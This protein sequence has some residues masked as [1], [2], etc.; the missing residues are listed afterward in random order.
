MGCTLGMYA[1]LYPAQAAAAV[2]DLASVH[3]ALRVAKVQ[4]RFIARDMVAASRA[5]VA[6]PSDDAA[7]R[8]LMQAQQA[9]LAIPSWLCVLLDLNHST[10]RSVRYDEAHGG[11]TGRCAGHREQSAFRFCCRMRRL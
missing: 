5:L 3:D 11:D 6:D 7:L 1:C 9:R 8:R 2:R 4:A 10:S